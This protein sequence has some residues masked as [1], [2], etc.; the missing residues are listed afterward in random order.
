MNQALSIIGQLSFKGEPQKSP[1]P[2]S[3]YNQLTLK[4]HKLVAQLKRSKIESKMS[5][6]MEQ[7]LCSLNDGKIKNTNEIAELIESIPNTTYKILVRLENM[8]LIKRCEDEK[9]VVKC[10]GAHIIKTWMKIQ[11][12]Y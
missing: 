2:F 9:V 6:R 3:I 11:D 5:Y 12:N 1:D 8:K 4:N 7:A 10:G